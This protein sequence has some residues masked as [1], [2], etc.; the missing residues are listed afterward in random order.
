[1][2]V[3]HMGCSSRPYDNDGEHSAAFSQHRRRRAHAPLCGRVVAEA[4]NLDLTPRWKNTLA[5]DDDDVNESQ[6]GGLMDAIQRKVEAAKLQMV[7]DQALSEDDS[8]SCTT[9][10]SDDASRH[11]EYATS[12]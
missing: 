10:A 6:F 11:V 7:K 4:E 8:H 1:M 5:E 2:G 3:E 12:H 9:V